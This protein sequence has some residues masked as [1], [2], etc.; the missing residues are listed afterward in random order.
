MKII[1][2]NINKNTL[3]HTTPFHLDFFFYT[4]LQNDSIGVERSGVFHHHKLRVR[5]VQSQF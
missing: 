1:D 4:D 5:H 2:E 3:H